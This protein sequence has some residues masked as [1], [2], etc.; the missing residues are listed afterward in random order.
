[1]YPPSQ[2]SGRVATRSS[3]VVL[4][5]KSTGVNTRRTCTVGPTFAEEDTRLLMEAGCYGNTVCDGRSV[6]VHVSSQLN[7]VHFI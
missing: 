2:S 1:M 7:V 4:S 6:H 3:W 5:T